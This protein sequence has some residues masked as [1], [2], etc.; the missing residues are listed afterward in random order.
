[1]LIESSW[2]NNTCGTNIL[3]I[4]RVKIGVDN[5][6]DQANRMK[7]NRRSHPKVGTPEIAFGVS[8]IGITIDLSI[9]ISIFHGSV[10]TK[11]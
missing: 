5:Q 3:N 7:V 4:K 10:R 9:G 1:M 8:S 6:I 2:R 11:L